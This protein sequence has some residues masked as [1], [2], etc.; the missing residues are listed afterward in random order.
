MWKPPDKLRQRWIERDFELEFVAMPSSRAS[1]LQPAYR[2]TKAV[3]IS[4]DSIRLL[5][6]RRLAAG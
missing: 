3:L 1:Q 4:G 2:H 6:D 5:A